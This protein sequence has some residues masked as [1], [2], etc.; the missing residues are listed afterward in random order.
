MSIT[1]R[2]SAL[3]QDGKKL[4]GSIEAASPSD[5]KNKLREMGLIVLKVEDIAKKGGKRLSMSTGQLTSFSVQLA[6]LLESNIPLF[7]SLEVLEDQAEGEKQQPLIRAIK[8]KIQ[9]G[10]SFT[11]AIQEYPE[12]FSSTYIAIMSSGEAIGGLGAA[13]RR[14]AALLAREQAMKNRLISAL[15]YPIL[16]T[17][18]L[19]IALGIMLFFVIPSIQGL[20]EGKELPLFT[21]IIFSCSTFVNNYTS[22]IIGL[23]AL[24]SGWLLIEYKHPIVRARIASRAIH[25]SLIGPFLIKSSIARFARTL[26]TLLQGGTPLN[27]ALEKAKGVV[28]NLKLVQAIQMAE[29]RVLQGEMLSEAFNHPLFPK[30]FRRMV[31]LGEETGRLEELVAQVADLYEEDT[32]RILDRMTSLIQPIL[33]VTFGLLIGSTLLA[34]LL[35]LSNFGSLLSM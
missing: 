27:I 18:L 22:L 34:I 32:S 10:V 17:C 28:P 2:Y 24:F 12:T 4:Q 21:E 30:L 33:L 8:E 26:T 7:D 1:F 19:V 35:P 29:D 9:R 31:A 11:Q 16:L 15:I 6:Q 23:I 5:A 3:Q 25:W 20:F 14:V 13:A